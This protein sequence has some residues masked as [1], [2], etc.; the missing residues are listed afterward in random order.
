[1]LAGDFNAAAREN[2]VYDKLTAKG[3]FSDTW[4]SAA[5]RLGADVGTFH[6]YKPVVP[7]GY[8]IDWI[9]SRGPVVAESSEVVTYER[10]GQRPSDH[11]PV[12]TVLRFDPALP[13]QQ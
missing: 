5:Q 10:G 6:N 12:V 4:F 13:A 9:L 7:A 1:V 8:H 11:F 2:P 3:A